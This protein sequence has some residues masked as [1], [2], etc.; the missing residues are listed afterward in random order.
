MVSATATRAPRQMPVA[1]QLRRTAELDALRLLRP[2]TAAEQA[3]ADNLADRAYQRQ[4][5]AR[6]REY[7]AMIAARM[8]S[9]AHRA[10]PRT[11]GG[12]A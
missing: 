1:Q 3:E 9:Q 10:M 2:L 7:G 6:Q 11:S 8:A 4:W 12:A 5:R